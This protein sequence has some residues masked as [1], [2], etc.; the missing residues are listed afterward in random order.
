[1][2]PD[3]ADKVETLC[4]EALSKDTTDRVAFL[5]AACGGDA[6][7]RREVETLLR[8]RLQAG[9]FLETPAWMA[10]A[11][12]TVGTRLG[13]YEILALAG[14][15]GMGS[16]YKARDTRLDRVVAI[17]TLPPA[18]AADGARRARFEREAKTVASL[19]H[20]HICPIFDVGHEA[21]TDFLVMEYLEGQT[22]AARLEGGALPL[23]QALA[24]SAQIADAL[25]AAHRHGIVHRDL[26][27]ANVILTKETG[28]GQV[29][30]HAVLLDFGL[31]KLRTHGEQ[32]VAS[33]LTTPTTGSLTAEGTIA[34]TL[35]YMAPEQL[36]G[37]P[38]DP[39]TD[40]WALG[41]LIYEMVAGKRAFEG[42]SPASLI[43]AIMNARPVALSLRQPQAPAGLERVVATCLE[44]DPDAR[45][46][47]VSDVER[48]LMWLGEQVRVGAGDAK[49]PSDRRWLVKW[50]AAALTVAAAAAVL[51]RDRFSP[52]IPP[53]TVVQLTTERQVGNG[54]FSPDA[55]QIAY[56]SSGERGDNWD[57]YLRLVG[58]EETRRLTTD[59]APEAMPS[60][61]PDGKQIA[62]VRNEAGN[63]RIYLI[64]PLGGAARKLSDSSLGM[65]SW[66]PDGHWLAVERLGSGNDPPGGIQ[67]ISVTSGE[68][69]AL[70]SPKPPAFDRFPAFSPDGRALAYSGC[71]GPEAYPSC[72]VYVMTLDGELTPHGAS[73]R[74]TQHRLWNFGLT[75][76]RD[77]RTIVYSAGGALW[78]VRVDGSAAP[79]RVELAG[80]AIFPRAAA[81]RDRLM[82]VRPPSDND[83][84]HLSLD[85]SQKPLVE[86]SNSADKPDYSPDGRRIAFES[87][88]VG[89]PRSEIWLA[90]ADGSNRVQLTRGPGHY[91]GYPH[92]SPDGRTIAFDSYGEGGHADVWTI[93]VSGSGLRQI[94]HDPSDDAV[95]TWSH[96]GRYL[97]FAS[98]R[99]GRFE[100]WRIAVGGGVEEQVTREGGGRPTES[101]DGRTLYY[102]RTSGGELLARP[103]A[104]GHERKILPCVTTFGWAVAPGGIFH[105]H[106]GTPEAAAAR[107]PVLRYWEAATGEDRV[108]AT[109][110]VPDVNSVTVSPDGKTILYSGSRAA[111][112]LFMIENFR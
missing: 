105:V 66:S 34:G 22:L 108:I 39:R 49:R 63:G 86:S 85:G 18:L 81:D 55:S 102:A 51:V 104:G 89:T 84:Y 43:S 67:L 57:I 6:D 56:G 35:P 83:L 14:A 32:P 15:G 59:P 12:L 72:D 38:A 42:P 107:L 87:N 20:P 98:N 65:P 1:M 27:P 16:V 61:S 60:W 95:P 31:A 76:T 53:P 78:R 47:A 37:K 77:G 91:Q 50:A 71:E 109:L 52:I 64:S 70:T 100:V 26:K 96:D 36:E 54:S 41:A 48:Q 68:T 88:P 7:L 33:Q 24:I 23:V 8:G 79:E 106:C 82:F 11:A 73:R 62:F 112:V 69:R 10:A 4:L 75:W 94:T 5:D 58:E 103:T 19:S 30:P 21:G 101:F 25:S 44:K 13:P 45:W 93:G 46:Q 80:I 2:T 110:N 29:A 40:I 111:T 28:R 99:T 3:A 17:K 97:Y 90:D 9:T 74:L 92:W